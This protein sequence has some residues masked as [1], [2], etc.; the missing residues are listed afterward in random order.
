MGKKEYIKPDISV[1][2]IE[3]D[4][5]MAASPFG[6]ADTMPNGK[7]IEYECEANETIIPMSKKTNLWGEE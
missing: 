3:Q 5:L 1:A 4:D 2:P 7:D 6:Q